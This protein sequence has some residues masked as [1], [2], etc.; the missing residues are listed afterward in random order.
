MNYL[1]LLLNMDYIHIIIDIIIIDKNTKIFEVK[2]AHF[3]YF[4]ESIRTI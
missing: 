4:L 3:Q 2:N 1:I